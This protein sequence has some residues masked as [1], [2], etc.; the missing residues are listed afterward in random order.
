MEIMLRADYNL[1]GDFG[2]IPAGVLAVFLYRLM[3]SFC[4]W[5]ANSSG[6]ATCNSGV[7]DSSGAASATTPI[8]SHLPK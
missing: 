4:V 2:S 8:L 1:F 6:G 3:R 7:A 5:I